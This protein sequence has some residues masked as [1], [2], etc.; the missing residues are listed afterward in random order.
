MRKIISIIVL[1]MMLIGCGTSSKVVRSSKKVIKGSWTLNNIT[2]SDYG[3][4]KILF[5]NDVYK[6]C[7]E[8]SD[9]QFISNNNTGIYSVAT[10]G[11]KDG[12]RNFIFTIQ[13][14]DQASG[15]YDFLLKP[16]DTKNKSK[17]NSGYRLKL[18]QLTDF[19]MQWE[20]TASIDGKSF[21]IYMNFLK[22]N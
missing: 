16:T 3:N 21:K 19:A 17:D 12:E 15:Y 10:E 18:I 2:Y 9:W 6:D 11:C 13:E 4:F 8:K 14:V 7:L 20:Q 22:N 5:F 1:S